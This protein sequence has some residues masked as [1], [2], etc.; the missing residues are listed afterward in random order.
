MNL[1]EKLRY[2]G[3]QYSAGQAARGGGQKKHYL[4]EAA[5]EIDS[6]RAENAALREQAADGVSE[7]DRWLI[8]EGFI[9]G[10][11]AAGGDPGEGRISDLARA[12]L[13]D[14]V[15]DGGITVEM[16]LGTELEA[17]WDANR[18]KLYSRIESS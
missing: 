6:L 8:I 10:Y 12:W 4:E 17:L 2:M 14:V 7:R 16:L 5:D 3:R 9:A 18:E 11:T 13:N 1:S 15:A